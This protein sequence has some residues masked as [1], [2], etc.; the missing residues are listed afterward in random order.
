MDLFDKLAS[1]RRSLAL[2]LQDPAAAGFWRMVIDKYAGQAHFLLELIQNADDALARN[3]RIKLLPDGLFFIHDGSIHFSLTDADEEGCGLTIGH[4]NSLTSIGSSC[5]NAENAIGK[6]GIG[7][8]SVFQYTDAPHIEDDSYSFSLVDYIVPVRSPRLSVDVVR[9][10]GETLFY[11]PFKKNANAFQDIYTA[12]QNMENPLL[13]LHSLLHISWSVS[14]DSS[15]DIIINNGD[16]SKK[17]VDFS[18]FYTNK[19]VRINYHFCE[20]DSDGLIHPFH[21]FYAAMSDSGKPS[22]ANVCSVAFKSDSEGHIV[23]LDEK[24]RR[25]YCFFEL[26]DRVS[27]LPFIVHAPFLLT[28]NREHLKKGADWNFRLISFCA[29]M[30][31]ESIGHLCS[32]LSEEP[33]VNDVLS[34]SPLLLQPEDSESFVNPFIDEFVKMLKNQRVFLSSSG[35]YVDCLHTR[36]AQPL[37]LASLFTDNQLALLFPKETEMKWCFTSMVSRQKELPFVIKHHLAASAVSL[38][39][40]ISAITPAFIQ[41]LSIEQLI[42]FYTILSEQ[43]DLYPSL[44]H[45]PFVLCADGSVC[46]PFS[47]TDLPLVYLSS[48]GNLSA[49]HP[50]LL[51]ND[52]VSHFFHEIGLSD[53]DEYVVISQSLI[54]AYRSGN[55]SVYDT[56]RIAS[57]LVFF[58]DYL[59]MIAFQVERKAPYLSLFTD[60][61]FLPVIHLNSSAVAFSC[62]DNIYYYTSDLESYFYG[63]VNAEF[64]HKDIIKFV[65]PEK[66]ERVYYFLS[67]LGL[68]FLPR[69]LSCHLHVTA[70][71]LV[72][73]DLHPK[74]L[75]RYD[76]GGQDIEDKQIDGFTCF[77][78]HLSPVS[79]V[80]FF[81][82]LGRMLREQGPFFF[83]RSLSGKYTYYEKARQMPTLESIRSTSA[84][85]SIFYSSWIVASD[86]SF[87]SPSSMQNSSQM[88][89]IY[90]LTDDDKSLLLFLGINVMDD[91]SALTPE[92]RKAVL[93]LKDLE[94]HGISSEDLQSLLNG[95]AHIEKN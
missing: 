70:E 64:L 23:P 19:G 6:F 68:S 86:N 67:L 49:V 61:S 58:A 21:L 48:S 40:I 8:K 94:S 37:K 22:S 9:Q 1:K 55:V 52:I 17:D 93:L 20:L 27:S 81:H 71:T 83:N 73:F 57:D 76:N 74:S 47:Q 89:S 51:S 24:N 82:L 65:I 3:I 15:D 42:E 45:V 36:L 66:R 34:V 92:Q 59:A 26:E 7:F 77:L 79:S 56:V 46:A 4:I 72:Q 41:S 80:S 31:S 75:R 11:L 85:N 62:P 28:E 87:V 69:L 50:D 44:R 29:D 18:S 33:I 38:S 35:Q 10:P 43:H 5:K 95:K 84:Y 54:P 2:H 90:H 12:L 39:R 25:F 16:W 14:N 91:M 13:F 78:Q 32:I 53:P 30:A 63:N 88:S 60:L